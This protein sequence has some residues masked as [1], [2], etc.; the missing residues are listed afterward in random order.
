MIFTEG[1]IV[2]ILP[3]AEEDCHVKAWKA[4]EEYP[5]GMV[6]AVIGTADKPASMMI[7]VEFAAPFAGGIDCNGLCKIGQGQFFSVHNITLCFES[8][9]KVVTVPQIVNQFDDED[10]YEK[11]N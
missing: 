4:I 5:Y 10:R 1:D 8:S 9:R 2:E 6:K 11:E 7:A 3:S